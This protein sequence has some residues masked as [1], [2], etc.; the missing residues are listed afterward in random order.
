MYNETLDNRKTNCRST[1]VFN[2]LSLVLSRAFARPTRSLRISTLACM[3]AL[4][5]CNTADL[6]YF[7]GVII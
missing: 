1:I 5:R 4:A 2:E 6:S 3:T 7:I